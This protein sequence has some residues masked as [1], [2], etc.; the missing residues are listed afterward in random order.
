[1][2]IYGGGEVTEEWRWAATLIITLLK[3]RA[4]RYVSE[5]L[6]MKLSF[7]DNWRWWRRRW[8]HGGGGGD[9]FGG[10]R[11]VKEKRRRDEKTCEEEIIIIIHTRSSFILLA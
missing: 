6:I 3:Q 4:H 8:I 10:N 9:V 11:E 5:F 7:G 1:V 2:K